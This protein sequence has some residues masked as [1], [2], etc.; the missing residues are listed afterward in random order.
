MPFHQAISI[1]NYYKNNGTDMLSIKQTENVYNFTLQATSN[2]SLQAARQAF[3]STLKSLRERG[4]IKSLSI[5]EVYKNESNSLYRISIDF[6]DTSNALTIQSEFKKQIEQ[7]QP[8]SPELSPQVSPTMPRV[9]LTPSTI[10]FF[11][12]TRKTTI[13][14]PSDFNL[15]MSFFG[16]FNRHS[17]VTPAN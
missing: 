1:L 4:V 12:G 9:P 6:N 5:K 3:E 11:G 7:L 10:E 2:I 17:I 14:A 16:L 13:T 8:K 15:G